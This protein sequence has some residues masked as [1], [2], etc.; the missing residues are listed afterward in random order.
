MIAKLLFDKIHEN[1]GQK[2]CYYSNGKMMVSSSEDIIHQLANYITYQKEK[3]NLDIGDV[4]MSVFRNNSYHNLLFE[5]ACL[6]NSYVHC[7]VLVSDGVANIQNKAKVV[8]PKIIVFD[9]LSLFKYYKTNTFLDTQIVNIEKGNVISEAIKVDFDTKKSDEDALILFSSGTNQ[10]KGIIL[11][12]SNL[13]YSYAEFSNSDIF[14]NTSTYLEL[15]DFSF[16]GGKKVMYAALIKGKNICFRIKTRSVVD[17]ILIYK[18]DITACVPSMLEEIYNFILTHG[19]VLSIKKII[20]GGAILS[21]ELQEF[22]LKSGIIVYNVYGLT[23]TTSLC[24]YST[25]KDFKIGSVGKMSKNI[26]YKLNENSE[27]LVKGDVVSRKQLI[28]GN[29]INPIDKEGFYNT[30]DIVSI[31]EEGYLY[32]KGRSTSFI[33]NNK[34]NF[35]NLEDLASRVSDKLNSRS[36]FVFTEEDRVFIAIP[37]LKVLDEGFDD[38]IEICT[39]FKNKGINIGYI[40]I[41]N[42][43]ILKSNQKINKAMVFKYCVKKVYL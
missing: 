30:K 20:C 7:P 16:S 36:C 8:N 10:E 17:N 21:T 11:S 37:N 5:I 31:D 2:F 22:F 28:N 18:P 4:I 13:Y 6:L 25:T 23:E 19:N 32:I 42:S 39:D 35:L 24:A 26:V 1:K 15:L 40:L 3:F 38:I 33:K 14:E 29:I 9:S 27:L 41:Y 43:D 12:Q 34:G